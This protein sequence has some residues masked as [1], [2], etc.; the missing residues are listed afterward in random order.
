MFLDELK[1]T[2]ESG[3]GGDGMATFRRET[4]VPLGGPDGGNGGWGGNVI[5]RVTDNFNTL[6]DLGYNRNFRAEPGG[7]GGTTRKT[8]KNGAN[9]IIKVPPGTLIR[10]EKGSILAD[11]TTHGQEWI[12]AKGGRGGRGN[13]TF[14]SSTNQAPEL[15]TQ[16]KPG[17]E[18]ELYLELKLMADVG[19]VGFPNAGKSSLVNKIS[20][21]RP[22]VGDYPFTTLEPILGIVPMQGYGSFVIADIPGIIEGAA[23]GKGLGHQFLRH[24]ERNHALLF[25][26]DGFDTDAYERFLVL[27]KE[28]KNFHAQLADKPILVALNK[29]DLDIEPALEAFKEAGQKCYPISAYS[30]EGITELKIALE[31]LIR[32]NLNKGWGKETH[33]GW[34]L[35]GKK[36]KK[37]PA[38]IWDEE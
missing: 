31:E 18:V 13:A 15:F 38:D 6:L 9:M 12:A 26:I 23:D 3:K 7:K 17:V 16:G 33:S 2:V 21:A 27:K 24:I 4:H 34:G 19:L 29:A 30:G 35:K 5:F 37:P 10:N 25:V 8:G 36:S 20:G 14:K 28:L 11:L 22:R 1:I 32:P